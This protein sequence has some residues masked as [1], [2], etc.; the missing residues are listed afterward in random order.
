MKND[1]SYLLIALLVFLIAV[2]IAIDL[3]LFSPEII[4]AIGFSAFLAIGLWSLRNSGRTFSAATAFV[5]VGIV[6]SVL[7]AY[8]NQIIFRFG[9]TL[10]MLAFLLLATSQAMQQIAKGNNISANRIVGAICVYLMLG[11]IWAL[12]YA[13]LEAVVPGSFKG[14]TEQTASASWNPDWVYFSFVTLSTLGYG[15]ITPMTYSARALSYFEA[16]VG[17]FY[18]AVLVAGLV[19][20]YLSE[21]Q[22]HVTKK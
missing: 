18:L 13:L 4:R 19:G 15:D 7:F 5:V 9:S 20:A 16:I 11:V 1:F 21:K 3:H 10:A 17:Q 2:P 6:L 8:N 22:G 12:S 14:L